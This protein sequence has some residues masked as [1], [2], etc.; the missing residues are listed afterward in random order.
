MTS[1]DYTRPPAT[2][3]GL[4]TEIAKR[5][6][7]SDPVA[8]EK[9]YR[10]INQKWPQ[11]NYMTRISHVYDYRRNV[12]IR[13]AKLPNA[14]VNETYPELE[15]RPGIK[16]WL[17]RLWYEIMVR[18]DASRDRILLLRGWK[19]RQTQ[20]FP[21]IDRGYDSETLEF[22]HFLVPYSDIFSSQLPGLH[23]AVAYHAARDTLYIAGRD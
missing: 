16:A 21:P 20:Y 14:L 8:G 5:N 13:N 18:T 7:F 4:S 15:R 12:I 22:T 1:F 2:Y 19:V 10:A 3:G 23:I 17:W 9:I 6:R 11:I